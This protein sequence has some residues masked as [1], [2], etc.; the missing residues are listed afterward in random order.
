VR[1]AESGTE[2]LHRFGLRFKRTDARV[3]YRLADRVRLGDMEGDLSTFEQA[4]ISAE[5]GEPLEIQCTPAEAQA[6]AVGYALNGTSLP[7]IDVFNG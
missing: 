7:T 2:T 4:A 5:R 3:L 6:L 1:Y